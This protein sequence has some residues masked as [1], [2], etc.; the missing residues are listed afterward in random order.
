MIVRLENLYTTIVDASVDEWAWLKGYLM[1]EDQKSA[2]YRAGGKTRRG[3]PKRYSLLQN[4][5]YPAGLT[6]QVRRAAHERGFRFDVID[7]RVPPTNAPRTIEDVDPSLYD[8]LFDDQV[9]GIA[10]ALKR[11]RGILWHP[12]GAGKTEEAVAL[13]NCVPDATWLFLVNEADLM[14]NAARRFEKRTDE[15]AGRVGDGYCQIERFTAATFQTLA[16]G[17]AKPRSKAGQEKHELLTKLMSTVDGLIIDEVH[18]LPADSF[19]RVAMSAKRA[20]YRIGVSGTP[21]ARGDKKSL[22]SVAATG[23]I[24]HRIKPE[25]LMAAGRI[26]RPTIYMVPLVQAADEVNYGAAYKKLIS[27]STGRNHA[28]VECVKR[29]AKPALVF[30]AHVDHGRRLTKLL[31][32]AGINAEFVWGEKNIAQRDDAIR[33]LRWGD[34]DAIV[35]STVFQTGTDIPEVAGMVIASG[36]K[37]DIAAIQRIGRGSRVTEHKKTFEVYDI[38]DRDA[39]FKIEGTKHP[40]SA[41]WMEKHSKARQRAYVAEGYDVQ[42]LDTFGGQLSLLIRQPHFKAEQA[43]LGSSKL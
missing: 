43:L 7:K 13:A 35:C 21:L 31:V 9:E 37:S 22:Y 12:T 32:K 38:L 11:T 1:F 41:K 19:F 34:L 18:T 2:F 26:A 4:G 28:V 25:T 23:E 16:R 15:V 3:K 27:K 30:V 14:H 29:V 24:I 6:A 42:V 17:L 33:R 39:G 8:W 36:G 20:Y 5:A 40:S 10:A